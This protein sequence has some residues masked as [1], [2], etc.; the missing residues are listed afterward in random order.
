MT[1]AEAFRIIL[2]RKGMT[3]RDVAKKGDISQGRVSQILKLAAPPNLT[4]ATIGRLASA[5]GCEFSIVIH[6]PRADAIPSDVFLA[7]WEK[8]GRPTARE[9]MV[10]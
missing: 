5:V 3:M 4:L 9:D 2:D 10:K 8:C 1:M 7:C 6:E